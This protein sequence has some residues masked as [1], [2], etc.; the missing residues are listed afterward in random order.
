M[1]FGPTANRLLL[2]RIRLIVIRVTAKLAA[3]LL[4]V[5]SCCYASPEPD[6]QPSADSLMRDVV[7]NE[8]ANRTD[9]SNWLYRV[10][11]VV[12]GQTLTE[13]EVETKDGPVHRLLAINDTPLDTAQ[14]NEE[15]RRS[16]ELLRNPSLQRDV[17]KQYDADELRLENLIR[18]LPNAFQ[19]QY[20]GNNGSYVRIKFRPNPAFVPPTMESRALRSM[21]GTIL[22][23]PQQKR[24]AHMNGL[25]EQPVDFG[26][27]FLGRL[28][29]GGT[30]EIDR[31]QVSSSH[32]K[33]KLVDIH[34]SGR[35]LLFKTISKQ[36]H[37]TRSDFE[38]VSKDLDLW[39]AE[40]LLESRPDYAESAIG[41]ARHRNP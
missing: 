7:A 41:M 32:W 9:H 22:I 11:R 15:T 28:D 38:S 18:L 37:E 24:L 36:Q 8:L 19:F 35:M 25:L 34:V 2:F 26:F 33:T 3:I 6:V 20:D 13:V 30:F 4:F 23:D 10:T 12:E 29:K 27:G 1:A 5:Y 16:K 31:I 21:S 40:K 39:Q 14:R 17:K